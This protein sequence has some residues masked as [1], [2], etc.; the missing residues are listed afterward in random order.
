[1]TP[2]A[3]GSGNMIWQQIPWIVVLVL[4]NSKAA[5]FEIQVCTR[6]LRHELDRIVVY[7]YN[8]KGVVDASMYSCTLRCNTDQ[9]I[10]QTDV[11]KSGLVEIMY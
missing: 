4:C 11:F 9:C 2:H 1:M 6:H 10:A 7:Q 8:L 3:T 5:A